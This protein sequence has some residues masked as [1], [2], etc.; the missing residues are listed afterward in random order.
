MRKAF[1]LGASGLVGR[2]IVKELLTEARIA[3]VT[4]FVRKPGALAAIGIASDPKLVERCVNFEDL[5]REETNWFQGLENCEHSI[6][7]SSLGT[8]I[9]QAGT[10]DQQK[11]I[12][13]TYQ[14]KTAED[15]KRAT[16]TTGTSA[17]YVLISAIGASKSSPFFYSK[18]KGELEEAIMQLGFQKT[19]ILRPS[20]LLGKR[21]QRRFGE[22]VATS[23]FAFIKR[24]GIRL[25][26]TAEPIQAKDVAKSAIR[27]AIENDAKTL[28]FQPRPETKL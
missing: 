25:P 1:V 5:L 7:F 20:L 13:F 10:K 18:I 28:I 4:A 9:K 24:I 2:E 11:L 26:K 3:R 6:L 8:T 27:S 15:Y 12:D 14:L 16:A 17:T 21:E 23:V 19:H 22:S